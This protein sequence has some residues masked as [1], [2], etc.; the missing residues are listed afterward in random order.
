LVHII[1]AKARWAVLSFRKIPAEDKQLKEAER[2]T[3]TRMD[4]PV[5]YSFQV[6]RHGLQI[7]DK[8]N[9]RLR[10]VEIHDMTVL[11]T[12][13]LTILMKTDKSPWTVKR[14]PLSTA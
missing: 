4:G 2:K 12:D 9:C 5:R 14:I 13:L 1:D 6:Y 8:K 10:Y 11:F 7:P 3:G